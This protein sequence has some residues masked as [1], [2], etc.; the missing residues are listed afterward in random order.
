MLLYNLNQLLGT[1]VKGGGSVTPTPA[2]FY[3]DTITVADGN[4]NAF[5]YDDFERTI[6][7]YSNDN[8]KTWT[9]DFLTVG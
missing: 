8:G 7:A 6:W 4:A 1:R 9:W 5:V 3:H 2:D